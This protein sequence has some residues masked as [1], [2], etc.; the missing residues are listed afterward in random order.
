MQQGASKSRQTSQPMP[1]FVY[2]FEEAQF[3]TEAVSITTVVFLLTGSKEFDLFC[4]L[5]DCLSIC[6]WLAF[7]CS[8]SL[9]TFN[10]DFLYIFFVYILF[11][12]VCPFYT[13]LCECELRLYCSCCCEYTVTHIQ[14]FNG[15][16]R[17]T[18]RYQND[19]PF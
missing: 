11:A 14:S 19:K 12:S 16:F 13:V 4:H 3:P 17:R 8:A 9:R 18:A 1:K 10:L 15:F 7:C 5:M 6:V 2:R